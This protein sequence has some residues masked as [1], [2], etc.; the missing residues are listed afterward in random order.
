MEIPTIVYN[1]MKELMLKYRIIECR[2][3]TS[4]IGDIHY[5]KEQTSQGVVWWEQYG[6]AGT[7]LFIKR[8][9]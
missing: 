9:E 6:V 8:K 5:L 2:I 7:A 4:N 3:G 1:E